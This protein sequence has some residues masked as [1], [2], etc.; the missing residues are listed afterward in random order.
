MSQALAVALFPPSNIAPDPL[1]AD[2]DL[3]ELEPGQLYRNSF[4][5]MPAHRPY[6]PLIEP[7]PNTGRV[8]R[9]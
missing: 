9:G 4:S 8:C 3:P 5:V 7:L 1:D 6:R 2:F